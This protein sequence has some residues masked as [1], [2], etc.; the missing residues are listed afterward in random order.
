[1]G[2]DKMGA[3]LAIV[4]NEDRPREKREVGRHHQHHL[5]LPPSPQTRKGEK[6]DAFKILT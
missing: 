2:L 1:M 5:L 4:I 6:A 3:R